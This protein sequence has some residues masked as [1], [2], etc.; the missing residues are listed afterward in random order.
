M[1]FWFIPKRLKQPH[2]ELVH[3]WLLVHSSCLNHVLFKFEPFD[4]V[5]ITFFQ[6]Q[7]LLN[8]GPC[9]HYTFLNAKD[10]VSTN[11]YGKLK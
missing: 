10:Y 5:S 9:V 4:F 7:E 11:I 2:L 8:L 1:C 3:W 6:I